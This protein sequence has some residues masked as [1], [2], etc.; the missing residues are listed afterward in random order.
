MA[1]LILGHTFLAAGVFWSLGR[2][3]EKRMKNVLVSVFQGFVIPIKPS[4]WVF[5]NWFE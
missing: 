3:N 2:M 4:I 1:S 5:M